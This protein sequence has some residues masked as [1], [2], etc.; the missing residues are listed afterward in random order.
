M[1]ISVLTPRKSIEKAFL[2]VKP[3]RDQIE[4]F[5]LNLIT[6]LDQINENESEEFHK[7]NI[8]KF[9]VDTYYG[10]NY[11]INTK[12]KNDLVIHLGPKSSDS[13]GVI[14]E[15][16]NPTNKAE[17][18]QPG[19]LNNKALQELVLYYLR[20]RFIEK[21]LEVKHLV[22]TNVHEWFIFDGSLFEKAFAQNKSL[23]QKFIDFEEKRLAGTSTD[24]FYKEVAAVAIDE[25]ISGTSKAGNSLS[26]SYFDI[27][28]YEKIVRNKN[29]AD[30]K[31]LVALFKL[32]SPEHCLKLPF[33]NDSNT[34]NKDFYTELLHIIGL[35]EVKDGSKKLISR[36]IPAKRNKGSIIENT[37]TQLEALDKLSRIPNPHAFGATPEDRYF[38]VALELTITW[39]N[40]ILFL[41]LLEA[42]LLA[43]NK[44]DDSYSFLNTKRIKDFDDLNT[45]F[46]Q[47]LAKKNSDRDEELSDTYA[48]IPYLNSSLFEPVEL[49][50]ICFPVSQLQ[51]N[52]HLP[53]ISKTVLKD[54][55]GKKRNGEIDTLSYLFAFLDAYDFSGESSEDI[56]E[57]NKTLISASVLGLIFE[58]INGYKDGAFFTPGFVT[59][60]M[61]RQAVRS[62]I[63]QKF[64][65]EKSWNCKTIFDLYDKIEDK[66]EANSIINSIKICDPAVGSGHFLVSAL[67]EIIAIKSELKILL[68]RTG[69]TLRDYNIEVS[70]DEL[71]ITNDDGKLY[72][73]NPHSD[74]SQ[75]VQEALFHEKQSIIENC[76]FGVDIN[77]NSV[78]ICRLR[79]WIE[80]LKNS[81]YK[82]QSDFT[83]LETLPNID[84]NI[85]C[86]NSLISRYSLD[87]DLSAALKKS[88]YSV[89]AYRNAV[90]KYRH[91]EN[92][93]QKK[94]MDN[95]LSEIKSNFRTEISNNDP[96]MRRLISR[97]GELSDLLNQ[98]QLF[99]LSKSEVKTRD[100]TKKKLEG[101]IKKLEGDIEEI[102]N[103][104]MYSNAFEWRFEFPEVLDDKGDYVG[105][106]LIVG[107]P[108]YGV[109]IKGRERVWLSD[110]VGVVP[111]YEIYY[112]FINRGHQILKD[113]GTLSYIIPNSLLFNVNAQAY[114]LSLF[115]DWRINEIL[116]CTDFD[117]FADATV[118]NVVLDLTKNFKSEIV[119]YRE[120][121]KVGSFENLI[122]S[123]IQYL[124]RALVESNN[125]NWGLL[126]KLP[127]S[128]IGLVSKIRNSCVP[129]ITNFPEMS[130]GLIAYDKVQGTP[131]EIR[132]TR[133]YHSF[134]K[135]DDTYKPWL[136]GSDVTRYDV[137]WNGKEF[138]KY[139]DNIANPRDPK[140]FKGRR[141]LIREITNPTIYAGITDE[142]LYFDPAVIVVLDHTSGNIPLLAFL[143]ILNSKLAK[144]YHFNG[145]PKA[146]KGAF[147][148]IL[149]TD[150]KSF[151]LPANLTF[152]VYKNLEAAVGA[153]LA[154]K[155]IEDEAYVQ[156]N[157]KIDEIVY[158]LYSLSADEIALIEAATA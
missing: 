143:G 47:I 76:L 111:D 2:K 108:P 129:A 106:D 118:R 45:L 155:S 67:N 25:L 124:Q 72:E 4:K 135:K 32:L 140:F 46:F 98:H 64:N 19:A 86:G 68:D 26:Y 149:V 5:K 59:M 18:I 154:A 87:S 95:F 120:T 74:E 61:S 126:F 150:V 22:V 10:K 103:N 49:E 63:V 115:K 127:E 88:K 42:Q 151:P 93:E 55:S 119:G 138:I 66:K 40:R 15:T 123:P 114:R 29:K 128:V 109:S 12:S 85:K 157:K 102:K 77:S 31:E 131:D 50:Q 83:E 16:K 51:P 44:G 54:S 107:N 30:D 7:N 125:L 65:Q 17:M 133:G 35:T 112:W 82:Q 24:F 53:I 38:N 69:K 48:K 9:L 147:P 60:Y 8:S 23:V 146:T 158:T 121:S 34:L 14:I 37:I 141:I 20:E 92:K 96:K 73:Y 75:S 132:D 94:E 145:S 137:T 70:N 62:L 91:A 100:N 116:D 156:L 3:G 153:V 136:Y 139:G 28:D 122:S 90:E 43:Y 27:R 104:I 39:V 1:P 78:K 13:V 52:R 113:G 81:Y 11:Y 36:N 6:L 71:V 97:R 57:E 21:N 84:I 56:Q 130:Q 144:F 99:S 148:K 117:I 79:L 41:K 101:D 89:S 105:F 80:L 134:E 33:K 58:K 110:N 142:E 152:D